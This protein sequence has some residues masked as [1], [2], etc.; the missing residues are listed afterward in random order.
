LRVEIDIT[1][2]EKLNNIINYIN[3]IPPIKDLKKICQTTESAKND[4]F[5]GKY[6]IRNVS[7]YI[8]KILLYTPIT[9][10]QVTMLWFFFDLT[11]IVLLAMG[12]YWIS[13][14]G[15]I[16]LIIS[17]I[18][19]CTDGEIARFRNSCSNRGGYL[20]RLFH[21]IVA[22]GIFAGLT[23]GIYAKSHDYKIFVFGFLASIFI[24]LMVIFDIEKSLVLR[25]GTNRQHNK[26]QKNIFVRTEKN[27]SKFVK[28]A[29]LFRDKLLVAPISIDLLLLLL[30]FGAIF[31]R[32]T[33][34]IIIYG[35]SLP[36][37]WLIKARNNLANI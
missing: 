18:L 30:L 21:D 32:I 23:F 28:L 25:S 37:V 2:G 31:D 4:S 27:K 34:V 19:D 36:I 15:V 1:V 13:I 12:K 16:S 9:G 35:I 6:L 20:D 24:I 11:G 22:P 10:N 14:L 17:Y 5:I 8:T 7:I 26:E 29:L 33:F 3:K